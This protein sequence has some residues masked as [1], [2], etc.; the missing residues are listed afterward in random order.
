MVLYTDGG[1]VGNG[2]RDLKL[3]RMVMVVTDEAGRVVSEFWESGGSNNIAELTAV[4]DALLVAVKAGAKDLTVK[5]DSRN[6]FSWVFGK[7]LGKHLNDLVRVG[8][9]R[10]DIAELRESVELTLVW[11]PR[12]ENIAGHYIERKYAA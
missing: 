9:L 7:K 2:Q 3:R 10:A 11:V 1:C 5:T 12:E 8:G 6:N 4:R